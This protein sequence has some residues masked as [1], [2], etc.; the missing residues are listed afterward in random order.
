TFLY[1]RGGYP[2]K[3][4]P[5]NPQG[6][7]APAPTLSTPGILN[8][9][10]FDTVGTRG[11]TSG[12]VPLSQLSQY[13]QVMWFVDDTGATYTGSPIELLAPIPPPRFMSQPGQYNSLAAYVAQ[14]GKLWLSGG[15][16]A[17]ATL[18]NWG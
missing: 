1:A 15:G 6:P 11:N 3:G 18:I 8:G 12:I 9:Y 5:G 10:D 13:R 14:G 4:Y 16:A 7:P 17:Y 2:W